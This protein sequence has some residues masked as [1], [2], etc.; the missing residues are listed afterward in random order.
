[1]AS[2]TAFK[3]DM[4]K[5]NDVNVGIFQGN[6]CA[7]KYLSKFVTFEKKLQVVSVTKTTSTLLEMQCQQ[8]RNTQRHWAV[9][10]VT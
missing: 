9:I 7:M 5:K 3:K 4:I 10:T 2:D 8:D 6:N 1:M